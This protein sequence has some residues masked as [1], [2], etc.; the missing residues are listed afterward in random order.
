MILRV[1]Y[2][3][4]GSVAEYSVGISDLPEDKLCAEDELCVGE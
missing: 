2:R 1:T 3:H 4:G